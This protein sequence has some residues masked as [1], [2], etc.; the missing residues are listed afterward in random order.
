MPDSTDE[1]IKRN[2]IAERTHSPIPR[3]QRRFKTF[4]NKN[5]RPKGSKNRKT[6]VKEIANEMHSVMENGKS[7]RRK[8]L[9]IVFLKLR[10]LAIGG[11]NQIAHDELHRLIKKFE[12]QSDNDK[13]GFLVLPASLSN[14]DWI[15]EQEERNLKIM[16]QPEY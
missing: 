13:A 5:G 6:I 11:E 12:P 15:K 7:M 10:N 9:E 3:T 16:Q 2:Q 14:E 1:D 4:G 8:S